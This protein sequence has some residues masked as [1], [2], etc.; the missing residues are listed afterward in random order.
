MFI[1]LAKSLNNLVQLGPGLRMVPHPHHA[2]EV[3]ETDVRVPHVVHRDVEIIPKFVILF[4]DLCVYWRF[5]AT[6]DVKLPVTKTNH[7]TEI[8]IIFY[9]LTTLDL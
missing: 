4:E 1:F 5:D 6:K 3:V 8:S 2:A 7:V 9:L